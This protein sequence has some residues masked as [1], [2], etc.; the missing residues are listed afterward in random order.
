MSKTLMIF[1]L[2]DLGGWVLEFLARR[3]GVGSIVTIDRREDYSAVKTDCAA[4]GSGLEGHSKNIKF[5]KCDIND[6][7]RTAELIKRYTPDVIYSCLTVSGW[8]A[9]R[10]LSKIMGQDYYKA[11]VI[12]VALNGTMLSK[13]MKAIKQSGVHAHVVNHSYPDV[14]NMVLSRVGLPVLIGAGN[15]D[16]IVGEIRRKISVTEKVPMREVSV[17]FIAEHAINVFGTGTGIPYFLKVFIGDTNITGRID[18]DSLISNR[19]LKSSPEQGGWLNHPTI[20]SSAVRNIMAIINDTNEFCHAPGP[21][22]LPGGYPVRINAAGVEIVL[23]EG[24]SLDDA[25]KINQE[26]MR[27]EGIEV[28]KDDGTV[29]LTDEANKIVN[30]YYEINLR[31]IPFEDLDDI[32]RELVSRVNKLLGKYK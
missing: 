6:I 25:I 20:A 21:N 14:V 1:G 26:G 31:E 2:G 23:P 24:I 29:V 13:L 5:E 16:N 7:E 11:N 4:V 12:S 17:Y 32:A 30:K 18:A 22:G 19:L 27:A 28:I 10:N 3:E 9:R 8:L 15:L